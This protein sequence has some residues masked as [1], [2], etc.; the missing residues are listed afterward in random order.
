[1]RTEY[2]MIHELRQ[3]NSSLKNKLNEIKK[4]VM[5][6]PNNMELGKVIRQFTNESFV[7]E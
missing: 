2:E 7:E 1:M 3:E 5:K 4:L 6:Y